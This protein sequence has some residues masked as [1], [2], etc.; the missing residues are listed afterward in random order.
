MPE[1]WE[2]AGQIE[3]NCAEVIVAQVK[4]LKMENKKDL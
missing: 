4:Y 2:R 3:G 1:R